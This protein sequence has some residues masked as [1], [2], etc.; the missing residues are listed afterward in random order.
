MITYIHTYGVHIQIY[1]HI[2]GTYIYIVEANA[3]PIPCHQCDA[4]SV[5]KTSLQLKEY[6]IGA[7]VK[8]ER[9]DRAQH[10]GRLI[11]ILKGELEIRN[12]SDP[13]SPF[14]FRFRSPRIFNSPILSISKRPSPTMTAKSMS[15][16]SDGESTAR[17]RVCKA[18]DRC[19]LK[20]SKVL[21]RPPATAALD[22]D[23]R[24]QCDGSSPCGRCRSDNAICVF[25]ERKKTHD[26]VYPKGFVA[27]VSPC[28]IAWG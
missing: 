28:L 11:R 14:T 9:G 17:K 6:L 8:R 5:T 24:R 10:P 12:P 2:R 18:C 20:K 27:S 26:K 1:I 25:G 3:D 7:A 16:T 4:G 19:R 23:G 22:A 13:S 21:R 15:P